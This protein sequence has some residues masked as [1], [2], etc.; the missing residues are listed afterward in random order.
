MT[1]SLHVDAV[2]PT[3]QRRSRKGGECACAY[4]HLRRA[5]LW[6]ADW[7]HGWTEFCKAFVAA[8]DNIAQ[9]VARVV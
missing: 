1:L 5:A 9:A 7:L 3:S 8:C 4:L 2:R 6:P